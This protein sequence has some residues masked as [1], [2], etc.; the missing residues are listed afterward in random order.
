M[1]PKDRI[2]TRDCADGWRET[3]VY[4]DDRLVEKRRTPPAGACPLGD[5]SD[6]LEEV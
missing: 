4:I 6:V 3:R 1:K 2:E 5:G